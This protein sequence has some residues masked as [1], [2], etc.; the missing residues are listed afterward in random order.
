MI[1]RQTGGLRI[2]PRKCLGRNSISTAIPTS[3]MDNRDSFLKN[4]WRLPVVRYEF[5]YAN[6]PSSSI[7]SR[8]RSDKKNGEPSSG[9]Q[10][11]S[12]FRKLALIRFYFQIRQNRRWIYVPL[13]IVGIKVGGFFDLEASRTRIC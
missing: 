8:T 13:N 2:M 9:V 1:L 11:V 10:C 3:S 7:D 6:W 5:D 12:L 4:M